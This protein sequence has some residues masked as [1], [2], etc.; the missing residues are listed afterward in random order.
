[1]YMRDWILV[2]LSVNKRRQKHQIH[3]VKRG[4]GN[5]TATPDI[6]AH[7]LS[8]VQSTFALQDKTLTSV[9]NLLHGRNV[10]VN[11]SL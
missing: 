11:R 2:E 8:P 10:S 4:M 5:L 1:M 6:R 7:C 9:S 3:S